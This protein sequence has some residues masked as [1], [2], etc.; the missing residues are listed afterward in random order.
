MKHPNAI[1]PNMAL[2]TSKQH[3]WLHNTRLAL[4]L[5]K[6]R[7]KPAQ[8]VPDLRAWACGTQACFGGHLAT[9]PEFRAMG[10]RADCYGAPVLHGESLSQVPWELF[11]NY[12]LFYSREDWEREGTDYEVVV[13]R[14][15]THIA[16]LV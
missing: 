1:L 2:W 5:W 4:A 12:G 13:K 7:V 16:D 3:A 11:G 9:W 15:E 10:V 6:E 8:V 14:L